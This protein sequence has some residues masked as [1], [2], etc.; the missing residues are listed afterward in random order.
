MRTED[1][2]TPDLS[3]LGTILTVWAHPDDETYLAGGLMAVAAR[4]GSRVVCATATLGEKGTSDPGRWPPERLG[5]VRRHEAAAAMAV[6]GV[7]EHR[8]LG[9]PDGELAALGRS[10]AAAVDRLL[11]EVDPGTVVTFGPDGATFHPDHIAVHR[12]VV[13]AWERSGR[14]FRLLFAASTVEHQSRFGERYERWGVYMSDQRPSGVERTDVAVHL[15]LDGPHLDQKVAALRAMASQ[16]AGVIGDDPDAFGELVAE[17]A[18]VD[19]ARGSWLRS[20]P[21]P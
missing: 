5:P 1:L 9:L 19:A 20:L 17:E 21:C 3:G 10:G 8:V 2:A 15:C 4:Q 6:L 14:S 13:D 11:D 12:W 7:A 16:T 18:F